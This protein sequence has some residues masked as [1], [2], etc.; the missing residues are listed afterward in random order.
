MKSILLIS[1]SLTLL[2]VGLWLVMDAQRPDPLF[3]R[4]FAHTPAPQEEV[5]TQASGCSKVFTAS[6]Q[7]EVKEIL[8]RELGNMYERLNAP[9]LQKQW[10]VELATGRDRY[11]YTVV[12]VDPK[13]CK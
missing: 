1:A 5:L 10:D 9:A 12:I 11:G 7:E 6:T 8:G 13:E 2:I 3:V 4:M